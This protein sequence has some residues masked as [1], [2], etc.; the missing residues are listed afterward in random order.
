MD[1]PKPIFDPTMS[2]SD[3]VKIIM[4]NSKIP[5]HYHDVDDLLLEVFGT[6]HTSYAHLR[7]NSEYIQLNP[8]VYIHSSNATDSFNK[9]FKDAKNTILSEITQML[10]FAKI[11][12]PSK[13]FAAYFTT[14]FDTFVTNRTIRSIIVK[15]CEEHSTCQQALKI[16]PPSASKIDPPQAV[17][18]YPDFLF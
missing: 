13:C 8:A 1:T 15:I 6:K 2:V 7:S 12:V 4:Q 17:S 11:P 9:E 14:K 3:K 10:E 18:F 16:D 5:L